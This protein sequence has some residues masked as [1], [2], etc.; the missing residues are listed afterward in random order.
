MFLLC[1]VV[2]IGSARAHTNSSLTINSYTPSTGLAGTATT[3]NF[4][5]SI[6]HVGH[7]PAIE[8]VWRVLLGATVVA[9]G[10]NPHPNTGSGNETYTETVGITIPP[11]S[12][13][14]TYTITIQTL[15]SP[16]GTNGCSF[17]TNNSCRRTATATYTIPANASDMSIDLSGLPTTADLNQPYTGSF[18]CTNSTAATNAA[19]VAS[20]AIGGLPAGVTVTSCA[21]SPPTSVAA[22]ASITCTVGGAPTATGTTTANG[23]TGA[24]NDV[25]AANNTA[26]LN[27]TVTGSDMSPDATGLPTSVIEGL[28]YAGSFVCTNSGPRT[29]VSA[30]CSIANLPAGVT[31]GACTPVPP[32]N[33][34]NGGSI[35]CPVLGTPT[36][37]GTFNL[38]VTTGASNDTNGGVTTGGNN[39]VNRTL[40]VVAAAPQLSILKS[41]DD[42]TLRAAGEIITYTYT[43]TNTG[44]V[45]IN[46]VSI[47]DTHNASGPAPSP[48]NEVLFNDVAPLSDSTDVGVNGSWDTLGPGDSIRFTA[49]YTVTQTDVDNLQ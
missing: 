4:T 27:I 7:N 11:T 30:T 41:A 19:T 18:T 8:P 44:N 20:C 28:P 10:T 12:T 46:G 35:T 26:S 39:Q 32:V 29:A 2:S 38:A 5:Y 34:A 49:T 13:P 36:V 17:T 9:S 40:T 45:P 1:L 42:D 23:S 3:L 6:F 15:H 21:P 43:V 37:N 33:V 16:N 14:G 22:G 25:N 24:T 47:S 48:T 31:V